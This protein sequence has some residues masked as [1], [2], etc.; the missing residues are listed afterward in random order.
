MEL[1][2]KPFTKPKRAALKRF[3]KDIEEFID[4]TVDEMLE[5]GIIEPSKS[6]WA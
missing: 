4:Q 6:P 3:P 2:L 5:D 1:K